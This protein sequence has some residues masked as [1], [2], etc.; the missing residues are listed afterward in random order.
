M[1]TLSFPGPHSPPPLFTLLF[2]FAKASE[3]E[4]GGVRG[5]GVVDHVTSPD[6][7]DAMCGRIAGLCVI[8]IFN[9]ADLDTDGLLLLLLVVVVVAAVALLVVVV[10]VVVVVIVVVV[11]GDG[12]G[13]R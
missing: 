4:A 5:T 7:F 11:A 3:A 12:D 2:S 8:T 10:V 6:D 9:H 13:C 1:I